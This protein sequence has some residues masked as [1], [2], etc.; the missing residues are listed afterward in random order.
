VE[1][2]A[3]LLAIIVGHRFDLLTK[4]VDHIGFYL[5]AAHGF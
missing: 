5:F 3:A 4:L 2:L 1:A